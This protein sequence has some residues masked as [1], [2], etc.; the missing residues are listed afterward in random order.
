MAGIL[1]HR[2]L[3]TPVRVPAPTRG[4][5]V[6]RVGAVPWLRSSIA[7]IARLA[8][9]VRIAS[10]H[11]VVL[12]IITS[13]RTGARAG[14]GIPWSY[15][16]GERPRRQSVYRVSKHCKLD[17]WA[18]GALVPLPLPLPLR[19]PRWACRVR[20][21][22][23]GQTLDPRLAE[24]DGFRRLEAVRIQTPLQPQSVDDC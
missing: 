2:A 7:L 15:E 13:R 19:L 9:Q 14:D 20:C 23:A 11:L 16:R 12:R 21:V 6:A 3:P 10:W 1:P 17:Y 18:C 5:R 4:A 22:S 8:G 24:L